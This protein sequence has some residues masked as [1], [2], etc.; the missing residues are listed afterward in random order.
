MYGSKEDRRRGKSRPPSPTKAADAGLAGGVEPGPDANSDMLHSIKAMMNELRSDIFAK[1]DSIVA[2]TVRREMNG[3]LEPMKTKIEAHANTISELERAAS[4]QSDSV[5]ELQATVSSL[6]SLVDSLSSKCEDLESR[7]RLNNIRIINLDE[8]LEGTRP[9]ES[10]PKLLQDLLSLD[11]PPVLDRCHR[12]LRPKPRDGEPPR[13]LI[14]RVNLF[15]VRNQI[16]RRAAECSPLIYKG[17]TVH[18]R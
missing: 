3:A 17:E 14:I 15:Q 5:S 8:G 1:F 4:E 13:P 18:L 16:L 6:A 7:Q 11:A 9:T 2:E 12:S 10:M